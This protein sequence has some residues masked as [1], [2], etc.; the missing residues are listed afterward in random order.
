MCGRF[1]LRQP[2]QTL[3]A[4]FQIDARQME[5]WPRYNIAPTQDV[6]IVRLEAKRRRDDRRQTHVPRRL[7][8]ASIPV[9]GRWVLRM[10]ACGRRDAAAGCCSISRTA[11]PL[12]ALATA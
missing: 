6:G 8:Q 5:L 9:A 11:A 1:T 3:V 10:A 7:S 2:M 4:E 12:Y